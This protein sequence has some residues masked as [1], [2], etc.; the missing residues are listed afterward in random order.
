MLG[1]EVQVVDHVERLDFILL[2]LRQ[3]PSILPQYFVG[4]H[5]ELAAGT[6]VRR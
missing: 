6:A 3:V 4:A 2:V 5:G 1:I